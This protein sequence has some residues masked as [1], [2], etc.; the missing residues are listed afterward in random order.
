MRKT[1]PVPERSRRANILLKKIDMVDLLS[2]HKKLEQP[3]LSAIQR[4]INSSA[5]IKGEEV[6]IFEK[7]LAEFLQA[8]Y[9]IACANGTDALQIALMALELK[10]GD[11]VILPAF[12]YVATAEVIAL[13][14]LQPVMV[15]VD[16]NT[17]NISLSGIINAITSRTRAIIPVH[18][19]GQ[20]ADMEPLMKLAEAHQLFVIEDNA[21]SLGATCRF[22][23]G[24]IKKAGTI[25]HIGCTSFFPT[26]NLGCMGDG[27]AIM[28]NLPA[29]AEKI[30]MIANHG[31]KKKYYHEVV[32]C[33]SRLDTLQAA[34]L[35][36]KLPH[37]DTYLEARKAVGAFYQKALKNF[38][39]AIL[40]SYLPA[41]PTTCNQFTLKIKDGIRDRLKEYLAEKGIPTMIYYPLPLY[42]QQAFS[43]YVP[44]GFSLQVTEKLCESV[45]ALPIHTEMT[46]EEL[47]Y[48]CETILDFRN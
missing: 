16:E 36:V 41:T 47:S 13:L 3:I 32:G 14:G 44:V 18:L 11:E 4:V 2:Q 30:R 17:F 24:T 9:V 34:I 43:K 8:D 5:F 33:N 28:T 6:A 45:L 27:G 31:Q 29:L 21:Q 42:K 7:K 37:L 15:D 46:E 39:Y 23:D 1:E 48:I 35:N 10:P 19:F 22:L 40:P 25:G 20:C 12:T 26:K 38:E